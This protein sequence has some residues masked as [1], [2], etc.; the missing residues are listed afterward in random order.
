MYHFGQMVLTE[1]NYEVKKEIDHLKIIAKISK[2][3]STNNSACETY[4]EKATL[5]DLC[6]IFEMKDT[7]WSAY[8]ATFTPPIERCPI[9][10]GEYTS[11]YAS[12]K[13]DVIDLSAWFSDGL[14]KTET[15]LYSGDQLAGCFETHIQIYTPE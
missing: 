2:C 12:G 4:L 9:E 3:N 14:W 13:T 10:A 15:L 6:D 7:T 11:N 8:L 5:S 1:V